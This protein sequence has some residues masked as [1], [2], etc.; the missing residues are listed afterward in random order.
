MGSIQDRYDKQAGAKTRLTEVKKEMALRLAS[1]GGKIWEAI[2]EARRSWDLHDVPAQLPPESP[3]SDV[4]IPE[5]VGKPANTTWEYTAWLNRKRAW[6]ESI[7]DVLTAAG[8]EKYLLYGAEPRMAG[9]PPLPESWLPWYRFGAACI[10]YDPPRSPDLPKF[11]EYG[12]LVLPTQ[13]F[14]SHDLLCR[15]MEHEISRAMQ[16]HIFRRMWELRSELREQDYEAA[17]R[18]VLRRYEQELRGIEERTRA[19]YEDMIELDEQPPTY[20]VELDPQ[21][22]QDERRKTVEIATARLETEATPG[23]SRRSPLAAYTAH[24]LHDE[25]G[26]TYE[27]I[28]SRYG[29]KDYTRVSK[30]VGDGRG[31]SNMK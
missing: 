18:E 11:A 1:R 21:A 3:D 31:L 13:F 7:R 19:Q 4:L 23:R 12:G 30:Y 16:E 9:N 15:E 27:E 10:L 8:V 17:S 22:T 25:L 26:W 29:W 5:S 24:I 14:T 28:A 20:Y 2:S 6:Y